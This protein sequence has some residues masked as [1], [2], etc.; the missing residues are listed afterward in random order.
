MIINN[1]TTGESAF[2]SQQE[3]MPFGGTNTQVAID[4]GSFVVGGLAAWGGKA[5]GFQN[6]AR[7]GKNLTRL[8]AHASMV[9]LMGLGLS[10]GASAI[11]SIS[12]STRAEKIRQNIKAKGWA[13]TGYYDSRAAATM[14]QRAIQVI[15]NSQLSTRAAFGNE[16]SYMHY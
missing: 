9:S 3:R 2:F 14:R 7:F 1:E 4:L 10:L 15:H 8:S 12:G 5:G 13:D 11:K 6:V 16:A